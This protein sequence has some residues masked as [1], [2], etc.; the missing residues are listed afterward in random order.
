MRHYS[1]KKTLPLLFAGMLTTA[2]SDNIL[3]DDDNTDTETS[4][5][6]YV[7]AAQVAGSTGTTNV[8]LPS[9]QIASGSISAVGN[10]LQNDGATQWVFFK[11]KVLYGLSYNQ[12]NA[13][14]T[15]SYILQEKGELKAREAEYKISRFTT[16]GK[17]GD[18][19]MTSS[20]GDGLLEYAD[21]NGYLP[22]MFLVTYLDVEKEIKTSGDTEKK[23]DNYMS[24][25]FLGNGE[26]VNLVGF[27]E[28]N[29]KLYSGIVAMGLSPY[30]A[31][32][33]NGKYI[34]DGNEDL[35][36]TESGG[37]ASSSYVKGELQYTQYPNE[38]WVAIF[39]DAQLNGKTLVKTDKISYPCGRFKS[40]YYQSIWADENGDVYVFSPSFAKI[41]TDKR[42]QTNLPAGVMRIKKGAKEFDD[43]YYVNLEAQSNGKTFQRCW[44]INN[45]Y[46]LLTMYNLTSNQDT[47]L[48]LAIFDSSKK[49]LTF[50]SGTP[51]TNEITA[52][53]STPYVEN[54]KVYLPIMTS[55]KYPAI[56]SIDPTTATAERGAEIEASTTS[57]VGKLNVY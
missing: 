47:A 50:V 10:G 49:E 15:R 52:I 33:D 7:V 5:S 3:P 56:Y 48:E 51:A 42:Q 27:E 35:V 20:T 55:D 18:Y 31:S 12:G 2:C 37:S 29:G 45:G 8:L 14:T 25:N 13:G 46:F 43:S 1:L 9:E 36:K 4:K 38:C 39:D 32:I 19:I 23:K 41:M 28:A 11:D 40:Q 53:G 44:Y 24:E 21:E 57:A 16:F 22:K 26:Y 6:R 30:G 17:F 54:G 34:K